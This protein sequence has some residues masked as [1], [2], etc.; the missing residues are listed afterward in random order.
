MLSFI[1][2]LTALHICEA[3][4]ATGGAGVQG[5]VGGRTEHNEFLKYKTA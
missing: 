4:T 2:R 1:T 3:D 5:R